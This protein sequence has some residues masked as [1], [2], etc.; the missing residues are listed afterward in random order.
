MKHISSQV[1]WCVEIQRP[2]TEEKAYAFYS[3][4]RMFKYD[5]VEANEVVFQPGG[6]VVI[7]YVSPRI[8]VKNNDT[9][10]MQKVSKKSEHV[11]CY[12][13]GIC[14]SCP[15]FLFSFL[16]MCV[17]CMHVL[18]KESKS[19]TKQCRLMRRACVE[20]SH[21]NRHNVHAAVRQAAQA[22][23]VNKECRHSAACSAAQV[24]MHTRKAKMS[25]KYTRS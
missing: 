15:N 19:S 12:K 17:A 21:Y 5:D 16:P 22:A 2:T 18:L 1:Q 4:V 9:S 25:Q 8:Q 10:K 23:C 13:P 6:R 3:H 7:M 20:V 24:R 11:A 14:L